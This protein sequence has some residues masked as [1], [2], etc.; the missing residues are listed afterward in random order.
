MSEL[1]LPGG[2]F[3]A[4]GRVALSAFLWLFKRPFL[5]SRRL[6]LA[7]LVLLLVSNIAAWLLL[8]PLVGAALLVPAG[9]VGAVLG[10]WGW[11]GR[12]GEP[13]VFVSQFKAR[14]AV[15]REAAETHFGALA[16]FF[17]ETE[18]LDKVGPL[19][20]RQIALPLSDAQAERLLRLSRALMVIRGTGD[21]AAGVSRWEWWAHF[22]EGR[23]DVHLTKYEFSLL[24]HDEKPPLMTRLRTV[25]TMTASHDIDG[26]TDLAQFVA[27]TNKVPHFKVLGK[28]AGVLASELVV[29]REAE[30]PRILVIPDPED[31]DLSPN[32]RGRTAILEALARLGL[33]DDHESVL[34][35]VHDLCINEISSVDYAIWVQNQ[36]F[37]A[38]VERRISRSDAY[39]KL[40]EI[41]SR[42]PDDPNVLLNVAAGAVEAHDLLGAEELIAQVLESDPD[43]PGNPRLR[44]NIAWER[45][46]PAAA[47]ANYKAA[48]RRGS[49]QSWQIG[50][51]Y[52]ALGHRKE[53]LRYYRK[54]LRANSAA[55]FAARN[56]RS[57]LGIPRLL[58]TLPD[59]WRARLWWLIHRQ[60][61]LASPAL[62]LWK[63]KRPE[64]PWLAPFLGRQA[65]VAG[66]ARV[67]RLWV[68][69]A[70]RIEKT[71]RILP[72]VDTLVVSALL[73]EGDLD[74][75]SE[76]LR[77]HLTWLEG[78]GFPSARTEAGQVL[79]LLL[80]ANSKLLP[81]NARHN[82]GVAM[83]AAGV[84]MPGEG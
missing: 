72:T 51:C 64:D 48:S 22:R 63:R 83:R 69:L 12:G 25:P 50:D 81:E 11:L 55:M 75:L 40:Q 65:L 56:A 84:S 49:P 19:R 52:A 10:H 73:E 79:A 36:W 71:N 18:Y 77:N 61:L 15:G 76:F 27:A 1:P 78:V 67:A 34:R 41:G 68:L 37:A 4:L 35:Y 70:G 8:P 32:L 58:P 82:L 29:E 39:T 13:I 46:E 14:S 16:R 31:E 43:N 74:Q 24:V 38:S 20:V 33:G 6:W 42:F 62:R 59:G 28:I 80:K 30:D 45:R 60:P 7:A 44:A 66:D 53:A 17:D 57:L 9:V 54:E 3:A 21:A 5:F 47:L 2:I 23:P 26:G